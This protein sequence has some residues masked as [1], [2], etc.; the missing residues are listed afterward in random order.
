MLKESSM[1]AECSY[2][3]AVGAFE[4]RMGDFISFWRSHLYN[5][6]SELWKKLKEK[7]DIVN[8]AV[9]WVTRFI[10][11]Y[12]TKE[13]DLSAK[14]KKKQKAK[15]DDIWELE[16]EMKLKKLIIDLEVEA[17]GTIINASQR[18]NTCS[19]TLVLNE[20]MKDHPLLS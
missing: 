11:I 14:R 20:G 4:K 13:V 19:R 18:Q 7:D 15:S 8:T 3:D 2:V 16:E 12:I 1:D 17:G 6:E 5:A 9:V 10:R